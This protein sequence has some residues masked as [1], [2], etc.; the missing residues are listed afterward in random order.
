MMKTFLKLAVAA[1][2]ALVYGQAYAFHSGGVAE[3]VGCHQMHDAPS[4]N[5]LLIRSD[6]SG[7]C[8]SCHEHAGDTGPSSYHISTADA[9]LSPT[10]P[11]KQRTP[12][13]DFAWLKRSY[14]DS[15]FEYD[16][17]GHMHGHNVVSVANGYSA[18]PVNTQSPGGGGVD[19][20]TFSCISCHDQHSGIRRFANGSY[21][22]TGLPIANSGSYNNS[23]APIAGATA[24][25]VYRILR[26]GGSGASNDVSVPGATFSTVFTAV[27]PSTYNRTAAA[28]ET[29]V[30]YGLTGTSGTGA[31][32]ATCHPGMHQGSNNDHPVDTGLN[33]LSLNYNAYVSSGIMTG[34]S[35]S[36][37][38]S[39]VPFQED[40]A[41]IATLAGHARINNTYLTGPTANGQVSCLSCHR[42]HASGFIHAV[43]WQLENEF[44]TKAD[45]LGNP[46]YCATDSPVSS[47]SRCALNRTTA[48]VQA[49]Y[50]DRPVTKLG[51]W[52]RSL[53][54]KCHAKD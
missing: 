34:S 41:D 16:E 50:Y 8:L 31:W 2:V 39:L 1:G 23:A 20:A 17:P 54:N 6:A 25:G 38:T 24:V 53:C 32:C 4:T 45:S 47:G 36:S 48:E 28:T 49:A 46:F 35:A 10:A 42:A 7:T 33:G 19:G 22:R 11:P 18:D 14:A 9:D 12:G 51:A 29:R 52:Q 27:A 13:G 30:A 44:L 43:R 40:T 26:G 21:A 5:N 3:C 15:S 37:F